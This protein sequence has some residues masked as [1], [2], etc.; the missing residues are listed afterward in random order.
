MRNKYRSITSRFKT[1]HSLVLLGAV[2]LCS[3]LGSNVHANSWNVN[4][5]G[6][7]TTPG[8]WSTGLP[9]ST[10]DVI[11]NQP[12]N[13][14]VTLSTGTQTIQSLLLN[15]NLTISSTLA[16]SSTGNKTLQANGS[17]TLNGG[18]LQNATLSIGAA[19][20]ASILGSTTLD[21]VTLASNLTLNG[22]SG[23][24]LNLKN[25][26]TLSNSTLFLNGN[27]NSATLQ[28]LNN[29]T[30]GGT[31]S[32]ES[33]GTAALNVGFISGTSL[34]LGSNITAHT[35]TASLSFSLGTLINQ[36][37]I[38]SQTSGKSVN[39]GTSTSFTN[40]GTL[41]TL[42]GGTIS[43]SGNMTSSGLG[44]FNSSGGAITIAAVIDNSNS[45]L[46][47]NGANNSLSFSGTIKNGN[48]SVI[49][50]AI[51]TAVSGGTL[52][53][54]TLLSNLSL[55]GSFFIKDALI[56]SNSTLSINNATTM[57]VTA[58]MSITAAAGTTNIIEF[59]GAGTGSISNS[60]AANLTIGSNITVQTGTDTG[61]ITVATLINQG[62]ISANSKTLTITAATSFT[63]SGN[64]TALNN[65]TLNLTSTLTTAQLG[66]F[67]STGGT[68]EISS[69]LD[70]SNSS[71]ALTGVG[72]SLL[73]GSAGTIKNGNIS[74]TGGAVLTFA[75]SATL[76]GVTLA[77][78]LSIT[79]LSVTLKNGL[80]LSN[81]T[82]SLTNAGTLSINNI[83]T[84][85][86]VSGGTGIIEFDGTGS[87][88]ISGSVTLTLGANTT[89]QTGTG[90]GT[91]SAPLINQGTISSKVAG[92]VITISGA[93]FT[94]SGTLQALNG[95][96]LTISSAAWS[97]TGTI[98]LDA[99]SFLT[100]GGAFTTASLANLS[101]TG[102]NITLSGVLDNSNSTFAISNNTVSLNGTIKN[103]NLSIAS[104]GSL[105]STGSSGGTLDGVTLNSNLA[106]TNNNL[107][108]KD[109]LTLANTTLSFNG[110]LVV[111]GNQSINASPGTT[112]I[113]ETDGATT[114][115]IINS[116][117]GV[118]TIGQNVTF[119]TGTASTLVNITGL[120]NQGTL[121]A[122]NSKTM[123]IT[124]ATFDNTTGTLIASSNGTINILSSLTTAQ[125]GNFTSNTGGVIKTSG[126]IDN[127]NATLTLNGVANSLTLAGTLRNGNLSI[128]NGAVLTMT[129]PTLDGIT[130]LSNLSTN[131]SAPTLKDGF[132]LA[133]VTLALANTTLAINGNQTIAASAGGTGIVEFDGASGAISG[134]GTL[135]IGANVTVQTGIANGTIPQP[136]LI[137]QGII[138]AQTSNKTLTIS[139]SS[140]TNTGTLKASNNGT[141]NITSNLTTAQFGTF[142]STGGTIQISG[143]LDNSNTTLALSGIGNSLS[144]S[145]T[146]KN[147]N[148]SLTGGAQLGPAAL[149]VGTFS[150]V[151]LNSNISYANGNLILANNLTLANASINMTGGSTLRIN[152]TQSIF[153]TGTIEFDGS[154]ANT[155]TNGATTPNPLTITSNITI[156]TGTASGSISVH[157]SDQSGN[158]FLPNLHQNIT[159][160]LPPTFTTTLAPFKL[161][162]AAPSPSTAP[163]SL[164][165][166][167]CHHQ[168][169]YHQ[170]QRPPSLN[171]AGNLTL[172]TPLHL[173]GL[174]IPG[175]NVTLLPTNAAR[176]TPAVVLKM[177]NLLIAPT[178][179]LDVTNHDLIIGNSNLTAV[180]TEILNGFN[181]GLRR[182][183]A[184]TSSTALAS[185]DEF[186][187]A[188]DASLIGGVGGTLGYTASPSP[189]PT[190][191]SSS[192]PTLA[193][194]WN[195]DGV[196][197]SSDYAVIDE[198]LGTGNSWIT[199]DA[200]LDGV[201]DSYDDDFLDQF[202]GSGVTFGT[203]IVR[204]GR[205]FP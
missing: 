128:I 28:L 150:N 51:L 157:Q 140:F 103:G 186:L 60:G 131:G 91:L 193:A 38:S 47:L 65:G 35:G 81:A 192:T 191:S 54:T 204:Y 195:L 70:N 102:G 44:N 153:G 180:Q 84:I 37:V 24:L 36:G 202:V 161:P 164:T 182:G 72:N 18:T 200:N 127:T 97:S 162:T 149:T 50:G 187:V 56:L 179:V 16:F 170:L 39:I 166:G 22:G 190:P 23:G 142:N 77:S 115:N 73:I 132:T 158:H 53:N 147:G 100:L 156:Q 25:G 5:N 175:G 120:I 75:T 165:P 71:L 86:P 119:Q 34:T 7:W 116:G 184:I 99:T 199:G 41:Q 194:T 145:G 107:V 31:G 167:Q 111:S 63:N 121:F 59:D 185:G 27:G 98:T 181:A 101:H 134:T 143:I 61:T 33:D 64:L 11:I 45:T 67:N 48:L 123:S 138:S 197:D 104:N 109:G 113:V 203:T 43:I 178:S 88:N 137:N 10:D 9:I 198:N 129:S 95:G 96:T 40:T 160:S 66:T 154:T 30:I 205:C 144:L 114:I 79:A 130:L 57:F 172:A 68:V 21:T 122:Q 6:T 8:N 152:D 201:V 106:I 183:A 177:S 55:T 124:S 169:R 146:I 94:N 92:K 17:L 19:G 135:T 117:S 126:T 196:V 163:T 159:S 168:H 110:A 12:G 176:Q 173:K 148:I 108:I 3:S 125:L 15:N 188:F 78:N 29:Q 151:T 155:I 136:V 2:S 87:N 13:I 174:T 62:T 76:D 93:T 74:T 49:N 14:T 42:N 58:N 20:S 133:N 105:L 1:R 141:L 118:L 83:Q 90:N 112:G 139:A 4:A 69:I 32:I 52:D 80:T 26:L 89:V 189:T 46:A 171:T 85:A 82:I